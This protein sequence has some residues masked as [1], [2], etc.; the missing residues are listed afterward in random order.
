M[1]IAEIIKKELAGKEIKGKDGKIYRIS[2]VGKKSFSVWVKSKDEP[3]RYGFMEEIRDLGKELYLPIVADFTRISGRGL[4]GKTIKLLSEAI[5]KGMSFRSEVVNLRDR[6]NLL[7]YIKE[8]KRLREEICEKEAVSKTLFG[9]VL[10]NSFREVIVEYKRNGFKISGVKALKEF[11][12]NQ[13]EG[14]LYF[15]GKK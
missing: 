7:N 15:I 6:E 4:Y 11:S 2:I 5:S 9:H 10:L 12:S 13:R 14:H 8:K 3:N 1:N